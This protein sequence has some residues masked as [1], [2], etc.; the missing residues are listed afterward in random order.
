MI[1]MKNLL[2][3][4]KIIR[5][6]FYFLFVFSVILPDIVFAD[7]DDSSP[8]Q[9][10][11]KV[12]VFHNYPIIFEENGKPTGFHIEL[13]KQVAKE[14]DWKLEYQS[15][16]LKDVLNGL[17]D[18][19]LDI[20]MSLMPTSVRKEFADFSTEQNVILW[21]QIFIRTGRTDI[22]NI[23]DLAGK[24]V[25]Y[26]ILLNEVREKKLPEL[27]DAGVIYPLVNLE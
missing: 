11:I 23:I 1:E 7:K 10:H 5:P 22:H 18:G 2:Y 14:E 26:E 21:G 3:L 13:L 24:K 27:N 15:G 8:L 25:K 20:G 16:T 9:E 4:F 19:S 12:G 6:L 17:K